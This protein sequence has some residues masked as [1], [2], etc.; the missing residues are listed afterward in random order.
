PGVG[1]SFTPIPGADGGN[2]HPAAQDDPGSLEEGHTVRVIV[3]DIEPVRESEEQRENNE[4]WAANA[5]DA[6]PRVIHLGEHSRHPLTLPIAHLEQVLTG[7]AIELGEKERLR[8]GYQPTIWCGTKRLVLRVTMPESSRMPM[9]QASPLTIQLP[10]T[11][12]RPSWD[13]IGANH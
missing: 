13:L 10:I 9:P 11:G 12:K 7:L 1:G 6:G 8:H 5:P 3:D 4:D 2:E